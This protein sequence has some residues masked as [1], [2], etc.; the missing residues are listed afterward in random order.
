MK[1]PLDCEENVEKSLLFW[2]SRFVKHKLNSLSNKELKD[3][4]ALSQVTFALTKGA[5]S[6]DELDTLVKK[7]RNAGLTGINTYFNPVSYTH[8][9]LPTKRIV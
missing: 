3:P 4:K 5:S 8:L 2:L 9:T 6:L 1:F 7:A